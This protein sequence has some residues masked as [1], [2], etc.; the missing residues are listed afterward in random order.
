MRKFK[1][2]VSGYLIGAMVLTLIPV[3]VW[4]ETQGKQSRK[5][6]EYKATSSNLGNGGQ[7]STPSDTKPKCICNDICTDD[8]KKCPVCSE[9]YEECKWAGNMLI[10]N[11][12]ATPS[13]A[14]PSNA[15]PSVT[16]PIPFEEIVLDGRRF[17]TIASVD[18]P[19]YYKV[20][21]FSTPENEGG[22][23]TFHGDF[24]DDDYDEDDNYYNISVGYL[25]TS[26][27]YEE[28]CH[29]IEA[30][31]GEVGWS[32]AL[33]YDD[34][35]WA[36]GHFI[37]NYELEGGQDYFFIGTRYRNWEGGG[38][39]IGDYK[40]VF[41]RDIEINLDASDADEQ[42]TTKLNS[43]GNFWSD[44]WKSL[45]NYVDLPKKNGYVFVGYF[46]EKD[47]G[48]TK[49][50][51]YRGTILDELQNLAH[52]DTVYAFW[53][54]PARFK[55]IQLKNGIKGEAFHD[56]LET[57]SSIPLYWEIVEGD[58]PNGLSLDRFTGVIS[59]IPTELGK[60]SFVIMASYYNSEFYCSTET[61]ITITSRQDSFDVEENIGKWLHD[62][63]GWRYY[64]SGDR[65]YSNEWK[66]V[67][68]N[69]ELGWY[70]FGKNGFI[71]TGWFAASDNKWYYLNP[72]SNGTKGAM[73]TGW[74]TDP[75]DGNRYYLDL[76]TGQMVTGWV[77]IDET[78]YYF[79]E[80]GVANSGWK[81]DETANAWTY[82][83]H[84]ARPL[85]ALDPDKKRE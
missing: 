60:K 66:Q 57:T 62:T 21:K 34:S 27:Q 2:M 6:E 26:E 45:T 47:G 73:Q 31:K 79:N 38:D 69:G 43:K 3:N 76:Q 19:P 83:N 56:N 78:W 70:H 11:D 9:D 54:E 55:G 29:E 48:G 24:I 49:V 22:S 41:T 37:I 1:S 12:L 80:V 20:L 50:I 18:K 23:Y 82:E 32:S 14:K 16:H 77:Y 75:Q 36:Y 46:T 28:L 5:E 51:N 71:D 39:D 64:T 72:A 81:W 13:D 33:R 59:G 74:L 15:T 63:E 40:L 67:E 8:N 65:Y 58:L 53:E 84:G 7:K 35:R 85:G 52:N 61:S 44:R 42:G 10:I 25:C 4:A 68:C 17:S 30:Y